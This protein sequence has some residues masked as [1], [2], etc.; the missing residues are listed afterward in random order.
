MQLEDPMLTDLHHKMVIDGSFAAVETAL[1]VAAAKGLFDEYISQCTYKY[2]V[3][4]RRGD[5]APLA[6]SLLGGLFRHN[7]AHT[8]EQ[9][10]L[11]QDCPD[12]CQQGPAHARRS[13]DV[14]GHGAQAHLPLRRLGRPLRLGRSVGL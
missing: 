3:R 13:P 10:T 7:R 12:R 1:V 11:A 5:G 8:H 4:R 14:P 9:G 2:V 6:D